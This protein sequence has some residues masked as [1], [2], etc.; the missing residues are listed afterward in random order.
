MV[1]AAAAADAALALLAG[2]GLGAFLH[3][4]AWPVQPGL[5]LLD[6]KFLLAALPDL[7]LAAF[8]A[9]IAGLAA[10]VRAR[11]A[12]KPAAEAAEAMRTAVFSGAL[13]VALGVL[14]GGWLFRLFEMHTGVR[15]GVLVA[16]ALGALIP[17]PRIPRS[18]TRA[19][20][21]AAAVALLLLAGGVGRYDPLAGA[22][23]DVRPHPVLPAA[24]ADMRLGQGPDVIL[25]SVDTLRADAVL[26]PGVPTPHLDALRAR[27]RWAEFAR[28]PAPSTLPSHVAMVTGKHPLATG[29]YTNSGRLAAD[30]GDTLAEVFRAAGWRALG[31]ASND[32]L[33]AHTGFTRGFEDYQMLRS[34]DAPLRKRMGGLILSTRRMS[35]LEP[36][37][38]DPACVAAAVRIARLRFDVPPDIH[39]TY[40]TAPAEAV[41]DAALACLDQIH[42]QERPGFLFVHFMDPHLPYS[43]PESAAGAVSAGSALPERYAAFP[44]M[45]TF[46]TDK[47]QSDLASADE[48]VAA[49]ARAAAAHLRLVYDEEVMAVDAEIGRILARAAAGGRPTVVLFT[50]DHGEQFGEFGLMSHGNSLY[51]PLLRVPFVLAGPGIEP[52]GFDHA[53]RLEDV[54][55]TLLRAAG[56]PARDFGSG[57]DLTQPFAPADPIV[58]AHEDLLAVLDGEFK[59]IFGWDSAD[60][61]RAALA[62]RH[63]CLRA[64][65]AATVTDPAVAEELARLADR[66]RAAARERARREISADERARLAELGYVFDAQG[67]LVEQ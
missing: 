40:D 25:V 11:R 15:N 20:G 59:A 66:A 50:A 47:V 48:A 33:D 7:P 34:A 36:M 14:A 56:I 57:R 6:L 21:A 5:A 1:R 67:N 49:D 17:P 43:P 39:E 35:G 27:G 29:C 38:S 23:T 12:G 24:P 28:A 22:T 30:A 18:W 10:A 51:E 54:G 45:T 16:V 52:G 4:L 44:R 19:L 42:A 26:D 46:L 60:P 64:D 62:P 2:V 61:R 53:P 63:L 13:L 31:V 32:L 37:M 55:L 41:G 3:A 58:A 9:G 65:E 8:V